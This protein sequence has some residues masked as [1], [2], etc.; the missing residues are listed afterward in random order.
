MLNDENKKKTI[1]LKWQKKWLKSTQV[2]MQDSRS[3]VWEREIHIEKKTK[4]ISETQFLTKLM[5]K[6]E[7]KKFNLKKMTKQ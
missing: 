1:L 3:R 2:N 7:R 4:K 5:L 6:D